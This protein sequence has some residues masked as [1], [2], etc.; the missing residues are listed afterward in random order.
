VVLLPAAV[1]VNAQVERLWIVAVAAE[2]DVF[3]LVSAVVELSPEV[4]VL[5]SEPA[6]FLLSE[7]Q[8]FVDIAVAAVVL[9]AVSVVAAEVDSSGRPRFPAFPNVDYFASS[10]SSVEAAGWES[11]HGS[12]GAHTNYCFCSIL[13]NQYRHQNKNWEHSYNNPSPDYNNASDT[14]DLPI[15]ATTSHSRKIDL[16][17]FQGRH[18]YMSPAARSI[19][20]VR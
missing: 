1:A 16:H 9:A 18:R 3:V 19:E 8:A 2:P 10:S 17:Q 12:S 14:N 11:V 20:V 5:V 4:V 7:L 6:D 15:D 13:A